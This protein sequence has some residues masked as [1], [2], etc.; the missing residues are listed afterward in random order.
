MVWRIVEK[1][2]A[3]AWMLLLLMFM[4]VFSFSLTLELRVLWSEWNCV[5][6]YC[7]CW[8]LLTMMKYDDIFTSQFLR[9]TK[10]RQKERIANKSRG[11]RHWRRR[12]E[13]KKWEHGIWRYVHGVNRSGGE[14]RHD[15]SVSLAMTHT[16]RLYGIWH[17]KSRCWCKKET[18]KTRGVLVVTRYDKNQY[19][20]YKKSQVCKHTYFS[21]SMF[22]WNMH[23]YMCVWDVYVL[24]S[25]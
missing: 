7:G 22:A 14:R 24:T 23:A 1:I 17:T 15:V 10:L 11:Q 2:V 5:R 13:R 9:P 18:N 12:K 16:H 21:R 3:F 4:F 6:L 20:S 25:V 8:V 19:T